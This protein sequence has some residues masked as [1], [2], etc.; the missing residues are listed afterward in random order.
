[1]KIRL[2]LISIL[3]TGLI[4]LT[5]I[6][7]SNIQTNKKEL[8]NLRNSYYLFSD[9]NQKSNNALLKGVPFFCFSLPDSEGSIW[10]LSDIQANIKVFILFSEKDCS[11]CLQEY[12]LWKKINNTYDKSE[13]QILG[14]SHDLEI[15]SL[16]N[17]KEKRRIEFPILHDPKDI[18]RK[19]MGLLNSPLRV[20]LNKFNEIIEIEKSDSNLDGQKRYLKQLK[21]WLFDVGTNQ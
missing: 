17:F 19:N 16:V 14:I 9:A 20:T 2:L 13:V 21:N 1:M 8:N 3:L 4:C 5:Y 7:W 11:T 12:I 18:V 10:K 15:N 6:Q